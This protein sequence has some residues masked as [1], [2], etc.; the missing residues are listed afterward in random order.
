M[1]VCVLCVNLILGRAFQ[2]HEHQRQTVD[3]QDNI[4]AAVVAVLDVCKLVDH[5]EAVVSHR[6]I[7]QQVHNR[8]AFLALDKVSDR[9][10][11]LQIV[12]ELHILLQQAASVKTTELAN[13]FVDCIQRQSLIQFHKTVHEDSV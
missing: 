10:A 9:D 5:I 2:L 11:V 8:C 6:L 4:G 7:I 1:V 13:G 3:E 12:H